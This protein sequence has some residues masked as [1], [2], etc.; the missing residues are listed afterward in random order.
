MVEG[1]MNHINWIDCC[2]V[3]MHVCHLLFYII[4]AILCY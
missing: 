1:D 2:F 3:S 4:M